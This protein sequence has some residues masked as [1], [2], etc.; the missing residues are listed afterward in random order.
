MSISESDRIDAGEY[1]LGLEEGSERRRFEAALIDDPEL[2][3]AVWSWEEEFR[4]L[5]D[6]LRPRSAPSR[7]WRAI[8]AR[9]FGA[10]EKVLRQ[11][12]RAVAFWRDAAL[13]FMAASGIAVA[14]LV[15]TVMRPDLLGVTAPEQD[16]IAA[17]V[18][19]DGTIALARVDDDGQLVVEPVSPGAEQRVA[20]LWVVPASGTPM[21]LGVL[22]RSERSHMSLPEGAANMIDA[23][24][25][26]VVT[27]EPMGGSPTGQPTGERL[28]SGS[29][30]RI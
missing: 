22:D 15:V 18:R 2:S 20:E 5:A 25:E 14:C 4:P 12:R 30:T 6:G 11:A 21:S 9:L 1:A 27:S 17:I 16:W 10:D 29:L 28:G 8:T 24:S 19:L 13:L 3:Q 23:T 26:F 7:V